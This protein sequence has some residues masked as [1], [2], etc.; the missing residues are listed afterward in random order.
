MVA[1]QAAELVATHPFR[2]RLRAA[3]IAAL[4]RAQRQGEALK[5]CRA[6]RAF[7][8]E[9]LGAE[10]GPALLELVHAVLV[11]DPA[12]QRSP[13]TGGRRP[14]IGNLPAASVLV[15]RD[16]TPNWMHLR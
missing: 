15:H 6:T 1:A 11:Q 12:L 14:R 3:H 9:E 8:A 7:L 5:A 2:E 13:R 10:P 4:Y 16:V